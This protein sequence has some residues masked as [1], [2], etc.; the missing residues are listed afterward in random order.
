MG[1]GGAPLWLGPPDPYA[2]AVKYPGVVVANP[3]ASIILTKGR[4]EGPALTD[5]LLTDLTQ[6][7]TAE[8]AA[9]PV[10]TMPSTPAFSVTAGTNDIDCSAAGIAGLHVTFN[11]TIG[12]DL[13]TMTNVSVV[14][15]SATGVHITYPIF[16]IVPPGGTEIDDASLSNVDQTIAAGTTAALG[17]GTLILTQWAT[18]SMMKI[19][20]T[21]IAPASVG[22]GGS[23]SG[24]CKAVASFTQNAVPAIQANTC[25]DCHNTGGAGNAA[26]RGSSR[27]WPSARPTTPQ[28]VHRP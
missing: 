2:S 19:E 10:A 26:M 6:W 14:T 11:A 12:G 27:R 5:P 21:A 4:H 28:R 24:G 8:A 15:P 17:P 20:F 18:G 1:T 16:A 3:A 25:L 7:L 22:D 23:L 9:L 13:V